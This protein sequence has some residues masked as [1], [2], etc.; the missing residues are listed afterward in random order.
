[1]RQPYSKKAG[2]TLIELIIGITILA[3]LAVGLL[4]ALDPAEQFAKA[5]DTGTRNA[6]IELHNA[7]I[8]YHAS[9]DNYPDELL[10]PAVGAAGYVIATTPAGPGPTIIQKL[11]D[12]GE[13]KKTFSSAAGSS[14]SN[15]A[16]RKS[17]V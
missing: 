15:I 10:T 12:A 14:L 8:R 1:M 3:L 17:V 13:L 16:D 6:A 11:I 9:F 7:L 4:A 5:R 2:F